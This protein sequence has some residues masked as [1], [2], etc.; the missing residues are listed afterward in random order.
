MLRLV[1][2]AARVRLRQL[3]RGRRARI[4]QR[5]PQPQLVGAG[6]GPSHLHAN[7]AH[8]EPLDDAVRIARGPHRETDEATAIG[9]SLDQAGLDRPG[10]PQQEM[11]ADAPARGVRHHRERDDTIQAIAQQQR[12]LRQLR[13]QPLGQRPLR[14]ALAAHRRRQRIVQPDFQEDRGRDL[15][16]CRTATA[17]PRFLDR[18]GDLRGIDQTELGAIETDQ[19]PA[20]PERVAMPPRRRAGPQRAPHQLGKDLP[21]QPQPPIRPGTVGQGRAKQLEEMLGQRAGVLHHVKRQRRQHLGEQHARLPPA[22]RGQRRH[23]AR[24]DQAPLRL[25]EAGRGVVGRHPQCKYRFRA[26]ST[27]GLLPQRIS[28]R[29]WS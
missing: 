3:Q 20:S 7:L 13:Q 17:R 23:A 21:W 5:G 28:E 1:L 10:G 2:P 16:E 15:G 26:D 18:R 11:A 9:E 19:A 4:A 6:A 25:Q 27:R 24:A 14:F 8:L 22:P 29:H 12:P